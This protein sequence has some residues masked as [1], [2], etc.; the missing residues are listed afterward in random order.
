MSKTYISWMVPGIIFCGFV[1][2]YVSMIH[3]YH[4]YYLDDGWSTSFAYYYTKIGYEFDYLN[5]FGLA[6]PAYFTKTYT[7]V[8]G[9]WAELFGW[10]RITHQFLSVL[11][12][13][14][15]AWVWMRVFMNLGASRAMAI[16]FIIALLLTDA[17]ITSAIRTRTEAL[18]FLLGATAV[19]LAV[20][21]YWFWATLTALIA[22]ETH[23]IGIIYCF[24]VMTIWIIITDI[25]KLESYKKALLQVIPAALLGIGYYLILHYEHLSSL[26]EVAAS[27]SGGSFRDNSFLIFYFWEF[28]Q[29]RRHMPELFVFVAAYCTLLYFYRDRESLLWRFLVL[30]PLAILLVEFL[31][32]RGGGPHYIMHTYPPLIM[33]AIYAWSRIKMPVYIFPLL[34]ALYML[35]QYG[36]LV[37][38]NWGFYFPSY[39]QKVREHSERIDADIFVGTDA[40]WFAFNHD[41]ESA[42]RFNSEVHPQLMDKIKDEYFVWINDYNRDNFVRVPFHSTSSFSA[43]IFQNCPMEVLSSF[44]YGGHRVQFEAYDCSRRTSY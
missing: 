12:S 24:F 34:V 17:F 14:L 33:L 35:P 28:G 22:V 40:Q 11:L 23:A 9:Q 4:E 16:A 1:L 3:F 26:S 20:N 36:Y 13:W 2:L 32:M 6:Q 10:G 18:V 27:S 43:T 42:L 41:L 5:G 37:Y 38:K 30:A 39:I 21:R 7:F 8:Y 44:N 29:Y 19:W 15:G 31:M 25:T